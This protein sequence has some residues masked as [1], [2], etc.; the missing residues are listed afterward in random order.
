VVR[1][2]I[3]GLFNRVPIAYLKPCVAAF[4]RDLVAR[5]SY[6]ASWPPVARPERLLCRSDFLDLIVRFWP[7]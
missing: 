5:V 6:A 4:R 1:S 3:Y 2:A 7:R